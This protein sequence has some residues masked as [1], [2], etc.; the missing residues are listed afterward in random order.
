MEVD[1][2][3]LQKQALVICNESL[4]SANGKVTA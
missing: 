2:D 4:V 3:P 1:Q